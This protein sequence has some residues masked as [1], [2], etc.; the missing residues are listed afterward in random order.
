MKMKKRKTN[1]T[2][3]TIL[4]FGISLLFFSCEKENL[5]SNHN[6]NNSK[7]SISDFN[8][9][10]FNYDN[11]FSKIDNFLKKIKNEKS[12][13]T[14]AKNNKNIYNFTLDST[15]IRKI[16]NDST[17]TYTF[18]IHR[19]ETNSNYFENLI[20]NFH[21]NKEPEALIIKYKP[22]NGIKFIEKHHSYQF[23]GE[24]EINKI[25]FNKTNLAD[26]ITCS[27]VN[28]VYCT[29]TGEDSTG[30]YYGG[31]HI[32]DPEC[33][34]YGV[35][36]LF[37][38]TQTTCNGTSQTL[39]PISGGVSESLT[40]GGGG[41]GAGK[42]STA[43]LVPC[44]VG[45][46]NISNDGMCF[47]GEELYLGLLTDLTNSQYNWITTNLTAKQ[48]LEN[49]LDIKL[50]L[51]DL[52]LFTAKVIDILKGDKNPNTLTTKLEN[53]LFIGLVGEILHKKNSNLFFEYN[54]I[55][56]DLDTADILSVTDWQ[57]MSQKINQIHVISRL[58]SI[59]DLTQLSELSLFDQKTIAENALFVGLLPDLKSLGI[60]FPQNAEEWKELGEFLITVLKELVPELIPGVGEV[61]ALKNAISAFNSEN[62]TDGSTELAFAI[63]GVFPVG[64][65]IKVVGKIAKGMKIVVRL[66]KAFKN[67]K[68]MRNTISGSLDNALVY[69]KQIGRQGTSARVRV[70]ENSSKKHA[71][72]FYKQLT[73]N[74][75]GDEVIDLSDP[76]GIRKLSTMPDGSSIQFRD[77]ATSA[78]DFNTKGTIDFVG[79]NYNSN[80]IKELKFND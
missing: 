41:A 72:T 47:S 38:S 14:Y 56:N 43:P 10:E 31:T 67:A 27:T 7:F 3:L 80:K 68:K 16:Q 4:L 29:L 52:K 65:A 19:N 63:V 50:N 53:E 8:F 66:T 33:Y 35:S 39:S 6:E 23:D 9:Y 54:T 37:N 26:K 24:F 60:D 58:Y 34:S 36:S 22:K 32:A 46:N 40:G 25:D 77:Y 21:K 44:E 78:T 71:E 75:V 18:L 59:N 12:V 62:Y 70:L 55:F 49:L 69:W 64:K 17:T 76:R 42:P 79:G 45:V 61:I 30:R 1:L 5:Y 28:I 15:K 13:K 11:K 73:K 2:K 57:M 51:A 74:R 20:V 48:Y